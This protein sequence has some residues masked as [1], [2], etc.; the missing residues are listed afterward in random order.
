MQYFL[1]LFLII[2]A[3]LWIK[4]VHANDA[5]YYKL[6][7]IKNPTSGTSYSIG[8]YAN[9]C[10]AG[11]VVLPKNGDGYQVMRL[12]RHRYYGHN[13]LYHFITD[14]AKQVQSAHR[15][16]G[17]VIGDIGSAIGGPMPSGH[18]SHQIGLDVDIWLRPAYQRILS[19]AERETV[20]SISHVTPQQ[21]IRDSWTQDYT[22]FVLMAANNTDVARI[23][24]NPA[25]KKHICSQIDWQKNLKALAK[26]RPW[27]GHDAHMHIRLK[28]PK[29]NKECI[30]QA[31]PA[32]YHGCKGNDMDW[33]FTDAALH[34]KSKSIKPYQ[35][36]FTDLPKKCQAL[37]KALSFD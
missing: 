23:F 18:T 30:N 11:G 26:I 34:P 22:D 19:D 14:F 31:P 24:V 5:S 1:K 7:A 25:I 33:W 32:P 9:G 12:S 35:K 29:E 4:T 37:Y 21:T 3:F 27:Y 20:S 6:S 28:C 17:I 15:F 2:I 16:G 10:L 8:S 13:S 36:K